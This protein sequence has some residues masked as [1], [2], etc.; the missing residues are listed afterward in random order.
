[1]VM[2]K[3][4]GAS[5]SYLLLMIVFM[6]LMATGSGEIMAIS[7]ILVYDIYKTYIGPFR[8]LTVHCKDFY[9][10]INKH[11]STLG[12]IITYTILFDTFLQSLSYLFAVNKI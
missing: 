4:L 2:D 3:V 10:K 12:G 5:G 1:M 7:S 8:L 6:A 9:L 11:V